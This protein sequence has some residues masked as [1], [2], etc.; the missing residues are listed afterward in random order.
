M[1]YWE[2]GLK[3]KSLATSETTEETE[4]HRNPPGDYNT[5]KGVKTTM[6]AGHGSPSL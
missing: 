2:P 6:V 4:G 5:Y 1:K 3:G